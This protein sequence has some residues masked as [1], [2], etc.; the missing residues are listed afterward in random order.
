MYI[1]QSWDIVKRWNEHKKCPSH[2]HLYSAIKKYGTEC[3]DFEVIKEI[4]L[5]GIT[6]ILLNIYESKYI[7]EYGSHNQDVGY[8]KTFGGEG[9]KMTD[10]TRLKV[11]NSKKGRLL[12]DEHKM[13][14][15][16]NHADMK[17]NKNPFYGKKHTQE[18]IEKI[19]KD[20]IGNKN[21]LG[22]H[23]TDEMKQRMS[24]SHRGK[25][26]SDATKEK[27]SKAHKGRP[28]KLAGRPWSDARRKADDARKNKLKGATNASAL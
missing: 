26:T 20:K 21:M 11:S 7:I 23:R 9:G 22:K 3:F 24:A 27:M 18:V 12:S 8:N 5:S 16:V 13:K 2:T 6:Q 4:R 14:V 15:S 1:G 10:E 28:S 25:K 19:R 17:G